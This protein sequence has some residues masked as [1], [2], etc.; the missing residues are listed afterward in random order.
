[1]KFKYKLIFFAIGLAGIG[2][3]LWRA[4][5]PHVDWGMVFSLDSLALLGI[6]CGLWIVIYILH[7]LC[8]KVILAEESRKIN[9]F[10]MFKICAAGFALNNV[11]P[12]GLVGGEPYRIME[13]KRYCS[14]E[15]SASATLTFSLLYTFGHVMLWITTAIIV[16]VRMIMGLP[17]ITWVAILVLVSG[18][19]LLGLF[20]LFILRRKNGFAYPVMRFL[21][22]IP[23]LKKKLIPVVEKNKQSYIEIDDNI[24]EFRNSP[25]RFIVALSIQF[26]TRLLEAFEY[27]LLYWF[28][29]R[30]FGVSAHFIDGILIMGI[31]SLVGNILF[32]IPMQASTREGGMTFALGFLL[33]SEDAIKTVGVGVGLIYRIREF[34][35]IVFG[36]L[37]VLIGKRGKKKFTP[38]QLDEMGLH[39]EAEEVRKQL[40]KEKRS[41]LRR[42]KANAQE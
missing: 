32:I 21:C 8:Y 29:V 30:N 28:F 15:K 12:A 2:I 16:M 19:L 6:L 34:I 5:L 1:M 20:L 41:R 36:I 38:E 18:G 14:T 17:V 13:L 23:L 3:L 31:A 40:A 22:K 9:I 4:D 24:R 10:S 11:T 33:A 37:L 39:E 35:F 25:L 27:F 7:A 26:G 42:K